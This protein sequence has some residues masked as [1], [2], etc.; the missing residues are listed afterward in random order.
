MTKEIFEEWNNILKTLEVR[1]KS[2]NPTIKPILIAH[3]ILR[4]ELERLLKVG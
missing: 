1:L 4:L 3:K 2:E